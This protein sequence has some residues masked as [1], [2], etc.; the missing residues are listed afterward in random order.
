MFLGFG[1][2][3]NLYLNTTVLSEMNIFHTLKYIYV[4]KLYVYKSTT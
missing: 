1:A 2:N 3:F 4:I